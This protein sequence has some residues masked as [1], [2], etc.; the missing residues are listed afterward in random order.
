MANV[1][2][3]QKEHEAKLNALIGELAGKGAESDLALVRALSA[4][5]EPARKRAL[6]LARTLDG[7]RAVRE[8]AALGLTG[9]EPASRPRGTA[10]AWLDFTQSALGLADA[11]RAGAAA[12]LVITSGGLAVPAFADPDGVL[13]LPALPTGP[14]SWRLAA[15]TRTDDAARPRQP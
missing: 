8:A 4:R 15:P 13:L 10:S 2:D 7:S 11:T 3:L 9:A 12:A 14:L 1:E 6:G 5:R